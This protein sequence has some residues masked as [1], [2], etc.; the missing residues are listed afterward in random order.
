MRRVAA[1]HDEIAISRRDILSAISQP[2]QSLLQPQAH[3]HR[4]FLRTLR[5]RLPGVP[6]SF[7]AASPSQEFALGS[8]PAAQLVPAPEY[9]LVRHIGVSLAGLRGRGDQ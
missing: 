2:F 1:L 8:D 5:R 6:R 4:V 3:E 9:R 7:E